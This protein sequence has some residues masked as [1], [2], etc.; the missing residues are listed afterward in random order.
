MLTLF[1]A[2]PIW[3]LTSLALLPGLG[4]LVV[5]LH[6]NV[7]GSVEELGMERTHE[8]L[9]FFDPPWC[10]WI[11]MVL[12]ALLVPLVVALLWNR[13]REIVTGNIVALVASWIALPLAY[14]LWSVVTLA[15]IRTSMQ[16]QMGFLG[17]S[18]STSASP[19]GCRWSPSSS[20]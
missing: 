16:A 14:F 1:L 19:S 11:P 7:N 3:G 18:R 20:E 13:D 17:A 4:M 10:G 5:P 9:W 2:L 6:L 15:L 12:I 8:F